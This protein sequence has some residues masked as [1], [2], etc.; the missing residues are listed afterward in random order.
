[1]YFILEKVVLKPISLKHIYSVKQG[2]LALGSR[3]GLGEN[4]IPISVPNVLLYF[5]IP[6]TETFWEIKIRKT[7]NLT[8]SKC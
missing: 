4:K 7:Q 8:N 6:S 1:M 3:A 2:I 5:K